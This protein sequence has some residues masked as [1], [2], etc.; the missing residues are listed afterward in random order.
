MPEQ[1]HTKTNILS[2]F[3]QLGRRCPELAFLQRQLAVRPLQSLQLSDPFLPVGS[4]P[5]VQNGSGTSNWKTG[6]DRSRLEFLMSLNPITTVEASDALG[7]R[8]QY[9]AFIYRRHDGQLVAIVSSPQ[10][11]NADY[12]FLCDSPSWIRTAQRSKSD[13]LTG[14]YPDFIRRIVHQGEWQALERGYVTDREL[15]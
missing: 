10:I 7:A 8:R 3:Y 14:S 12:L 2:D 1:T 4:W 13:L 15:V 9:H 5:V 11:Q 6:I